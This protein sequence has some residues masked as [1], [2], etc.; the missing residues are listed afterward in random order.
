VERF[1]KIS[2]QFG[3]QSIVNRAPNRH[4]KWQWRSIWIDAGESARKAE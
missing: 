2:R 4:N 3:L 1:R